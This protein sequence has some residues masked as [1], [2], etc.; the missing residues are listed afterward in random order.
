MSCL[1]MKAGQPSIKKS[2]RARTLSSEL[3]VRKTHQT[4]PTALDCI[5]TSPAL[6]GHLTTDETDPM[7]SNW[8]YGTH[9]LEA[10]VDESPHRILKCFLAAKT[11]P[12]TTPKELLVQRIEQQGI[13]VQRIKFEKLSQMVG[14][15]NHQGL[16]VEALPETQS[17]LP[18]MLKKAEAAGEPPLLLFLDRLVDPRNLGACFRSAYA[19]GFHGLIRTRDHSSPLTATVRKVACG[20]TEKLP[21][22]EVS[23]LSQALKQLGQRQPI[24]RVGLAMDGEVRLDDLAAGPE[25]IALILGSEASG[26]RQLTQRQCDVLCSI[27]MVEPRFSLNASAAATVACF[28]L[29]R[30]YR[31]VSKL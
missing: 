11:M 31:A 2:A 1:S 3:S 23:N 21:W 26:M 6:V 27:P 15:V 16:V 12:S 4:P 20:A 14:D 24:L 17:S 19:A 28:E 29:R 5:L 10:L 18:A 9:C 25:G 30:R 8:F 22:L 13:K 7:A